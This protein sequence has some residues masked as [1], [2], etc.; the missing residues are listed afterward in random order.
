MPIY[1]KHLL[2]RA[3]GVSVSSMQQMYASIIEEIKAKHWI[4]PVSIWKCSR[5]LGVSPSS[6]AGDCMEREL[7]SSN[8]KK[9]RQKNMALKFAIDMVVHVFTLRLEE[10]YING[11]FHTDCSLIIRR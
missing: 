6:L 3:S 7:L 1:K 5:C 8:R 11:C 4:V 2:K 10:F 9:L